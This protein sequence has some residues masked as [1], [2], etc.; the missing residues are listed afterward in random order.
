MAT[1]AHLL[2]DR[3]GIEKYNSLTA[4]VGRLLQV[5]CFVEMRDERMLTTS[6]LI[7]RRRF[8]LSSQYAEQVEQTSLQAGAAVINENPTK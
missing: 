5:S 8:T 4:N 7:T 1:K 2:K 6:C 3:R